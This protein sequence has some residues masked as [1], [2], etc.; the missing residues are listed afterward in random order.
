MKYTF[1]IGTMVFVSAFGTHIAKAEMSTKAVQTIKQTTK[2]VITKKQTKPVAIKPMLLDGTYKTDTT[3]S[4]VSWDVKKIGGKHNGTVALKNGTLTVKN[5]VITAGSF[6]L[7]MS[8][9]AS[10]DLTGD[11]KEKLENHL[12]SK[13]FFDAERFPVATFTIKK[14]ETMSRASGRV[15]LSGDLTMKGKTAPVVFEATVKTEGNAF[16]AKTEKFIV[17]RATWGLTYGDKLIGSVLNRT[18]DKNIQMNIALAA[19]K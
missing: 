15:R 13:D 10:L 7:D 4:T 12:E 17:D 9:V 2:K 8:Q 6:E 16:T 19:T 5:G 14:S 18:I 1:I 11:M 3:K